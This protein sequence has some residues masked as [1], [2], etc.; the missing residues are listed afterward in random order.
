MG[1]LSACPTLIF[2]NVKPQMLTQTWAEKGEE[3]PISERRSL[4][5]PKVVI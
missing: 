2:S 5:D 3:N 4:P 1:L